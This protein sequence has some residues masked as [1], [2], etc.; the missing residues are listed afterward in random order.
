MAALAPALVAPLV[1]GEP[2]IDRLLVLS[3]VVLGAAL[4]FLLIPMVI[5]LHRRSVMGSFACRLWSC[6]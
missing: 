5:L 1:F 4:P 6:A 2:S 3:Q